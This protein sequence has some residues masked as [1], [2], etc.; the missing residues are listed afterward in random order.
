MKHILRFLIFFHRWVGIALC[1]VFLLWFPSGIGMMYW[2]YPSVS[3]GRSSRPFSETRPRQNRFVARR[4]RREGRLAGK[5]GTS[6][7]EFI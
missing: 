2:G 7:A 4:G 1:L 5:P 3:G 6:P